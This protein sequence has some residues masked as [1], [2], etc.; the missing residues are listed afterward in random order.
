[1]NG[2]TSL[3]RIGLIAKR[4]FT[5]SVVRRGFLIGILLTPV[6]AF[7]VMSAI[8][9]ITNARSPQVVGQVAVLD[10]TQVVRGPLAE[11]LA[12]EEILRR[13]AENSRR[14]VAQVAPGAQGAA[15]ATAVNAATRGGLPPRLELVN[16]AAGD[17]VEAAKK[18]LATPVQGTRRLALIVIPPD[19]VTRPAGQAAYGTYQL[20]LTTGIDEATEN[21][22]HDGL[23]QALVR[24]RLTGGGMDPAA[25][26]SMMRVTRPATM[27]IAAEG[28]QRRSRGLNRMLPFIMGLLLFIGVMTGG[29]TLMTSTVEE[30]SS[31]VVEVLL[32]AVSPLELMWGKL[33]GQLGVSLLVLAVYI[34]MGLLGLLQFAMFGLID[35]MLVLWV[36]A[37]FIATYLVF[38]ALMLAIGG[39]VN[40]MAD[41]QSLIGPVILLLVLPYVLTPMV[42]QNPNSVFSTVL[43]FVPPFNTFIMLARMA[44]VS[45]PPVWQSLL[46]LLIALLAAAGAVWFAAKV[47]RIGLL[48]HGKPPNLATLIRWVRMA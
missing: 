38:G 26:E 18:W 24:A 8:P 41:A 2:G 48:M 34:G 23:R 20:Y 30:K 10:A 17:D 19:A 15:A 13:R 37:F 12:P 3:G 21:A 31:R 4:E 46:S 7:V 42:G 33:F 40:Q 44:S 1:M 35:P 22:I 28:E 39:A 6:L 25:V 14:A 16:A 29:Q 43:S 45:P 47:F 27:T 9:R 36:F 11:A 32:A 5:T